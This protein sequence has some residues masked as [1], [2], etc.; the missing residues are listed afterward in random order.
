[1]VESLV[2]SA[3]GGDQ[4]VGWVDG[5][6]GVE[7]SEPWAQHAREGLGEEQRNPA[8]GRRDDVAVGTGQAKDEP[9]EAK[10]AQVGRA[11]GP[12]RQSVVESRQ[13]GLLWTVDCELSTAPKAP[14]NPRVTEAEARD[15]QAVLVGGG[16][17]HALE[18]GRGHGAVVGEPLDGE[19]AAVGVSADLA[20]M[21]EVVDVAADAEVAVEKI[22]VELFDEDGGAVEAEN[23]AGEARVSLLEG[24]EGTDLLLGHADEDD[25]LLPFERGEARLGH[26]FLTL[27]RLERNDGDAVAGGEGFHGADEPSSHLAQQGWGG[28][29]V[30]TVAEEEAAD[31]TSRRRRGHARERSG[32]P[33]R[34][35]RYAAH[36]S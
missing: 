17:N 12:R 10:P 29:F 27:P 5:R 34:A 28:Y 15:T 36:E 13:R 23:R 31:S 35:Q 7:A 6:R 32:N 9:L 3:P 2:E 24:A 25:A 20:Q 21:I 19:Q 26:I 30:A 16:E 33:R 1:M 14:H 8:S 4:R 11:C 18:S 22:D